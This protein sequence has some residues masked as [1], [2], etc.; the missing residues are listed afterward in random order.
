[1]KS[2]VTRI[3]RT[4]QGP[5][6]SKHA[7]VQTALERQARLFPE[8]FSLP[9]TNNAIGTHRTKKLRAA[10]RAPR[11]MPSRAAPAIVHP[12]RVLLSQIQAKSVTRNAAR[13][14]VKNLCEEPINCG[15]NNERNVVIIAAN[16]P[17]NRADIAAAIVT[18]PA[19]MAQ[20]TMRHAA[21]FLPANS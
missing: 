20:L 9:G 21:K 7:R 6:T 13:A 17:A 19:I 18:P 3:L 14:S 8:E 5:M 15:L 4:H 10:T 16:E 2:L 12:R 11:T 1:M